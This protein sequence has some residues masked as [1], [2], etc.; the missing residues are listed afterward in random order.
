MG[1][2]G[3]VNQSLIALIWL[4]EINVEIGGGLENECS[5]GKKLDCYVDGFFN[6]TV[7]QFHG[8]FYHSCP[9]CFHPYDYNPVTNEKCCNL[10]SR[11]KKFTYRL[12]RVG[13]KVLEKWG[14]DFL[15]QKIF[16]NNELTMMEKMFF[17]IHTVGTKRCSLWR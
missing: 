8:C 1:Y 4:D 2:R 3:K 6:N 14:C 12:E 11:T 13:Y 10:Y 7:Y 9:N 15:K 17:S 16:S 5:K